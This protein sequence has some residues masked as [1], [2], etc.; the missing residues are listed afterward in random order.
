MSCLAPIVSLSIAHYPNVCKELRAEWRIYFGLSNRVRPG[1][2]RLERQAL[3]NAGCSVAGEYVG[4]KSDLVVMR[5]S[6]SLI[7][8]SGWGRI[9]RANHNPPKMSLRH[10]LLGLQRLEGMVDRTISTEKR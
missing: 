6:R 3:V 7:F 8:I 1:S 10:Y 4:F 5:T 2:I 9:C